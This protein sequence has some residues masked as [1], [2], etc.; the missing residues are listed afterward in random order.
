MG[1]TGCRG[2]RTEGG[3]LM[4]TKI[5]T[6]HYRIRDW[7]KHFENSESR[8]VRALSWVPMKN[9]HDGAGYRRVASLPNAT[10]VFCGWCL[11][12]QVASRMPT[13][14]TLADDD[15][16]LDAADLA[17]KTGYPEEIFTAAFDALTHSK[18]RWLELVSPEVSG[19]EGHISGGAGKFPGAPGE[20][21]VE[22]NRTEQKDIIQTEG[23]VSVDEAAWVE[24]IQ[25]AYPDRSWPT[26]TVDWIVTAIRGGVAPDAILSGTRE[27]ARLIAENYPSGIDNRYVPKARSF[28]KGRLWESPSTHFAG[29]GADA[30]QNGKS[31]RIPTGV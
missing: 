11:I 30:P 5:N 26:E 12:V 31:N 19:D 21:G 8:K 10:L 14:G 16:P 9:K 29:K 6:P 2:D 17:A 24:K 4:D 18:V 3:G 13:R 20:N 25:A 23:S 15:G 1:R 7:H 22:Q 27:A 28:F